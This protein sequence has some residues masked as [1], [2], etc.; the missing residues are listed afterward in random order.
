MRNGPGSGGDEFPELITGEP[1]ADEPPN[2]PPEGNNGTIE[3]KFAPDDVSAKGVFAGYG[4]VFGNVD[5]HG[6]VIA[7]GAF[8]ETLKVWEGRGRPQHEVDA[9]H[10]G[11]SI[12]RDDLPIGVWTGMTEDSRGCGSRENLSSGIRFR[13]A[14]LRAD[15]G[16]RTWRAVHRLPREAGNQG[17]RVSTPKR[18]LQEII[19]AEVPCG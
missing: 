13:P 3:V 6:D 10:D 19:L 18:T 16:R 11:Q 15:E 2:K 5:S 8:K 4:A 9:R 7:P 17:R 14:D 1:K 12:L